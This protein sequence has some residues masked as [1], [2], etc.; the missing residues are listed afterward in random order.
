MPSFEKAKRQLRKEEEIREEKVGIRGKESQKVKELL[1]TSDDI[2]EK[3]RQTEEGKKNEE[4]IRQYAQELGI[5]KEE[6]EKNF[7][8]GLRHNIKAGYKLDLI[9]AQED[10]E[11]IIGA[12]VLNFRSTLRFFLRKK[13]KREEEETP[14]II[15]EIAKRGYLV[16]PRIL[17]ELKEEY[18][19]VEDGIIKHFAVN[20]PTNPKE[21]LKKALN[22]VKELKEEN[23]DIEDWIIKHF[24][25]RYPKNPKEALKKA[26]NTIKDLKDKYPNIE[27]WII[28]RFVVYNPTKKEEDFENILKTIDELKETYPNVDE[29]MIK[30][31][32]IAYNQPK[33]LLKE[34]QKDPE[35]MKELEE[36]TRKFKSLFI[37]KKN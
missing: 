4:K 6:L 30:I 25:V 15:I 18:S 26:L 31:V 13:E 32:A 29:E 20:N 22:T 33:E 35:K 34:A 9:N 7:K 28:K 24:A 11:D 3:L 1:E 2:L 19:D 36:F 14:G 16:P 10:I 8:D 23:P 21:A 37:L 12:Y 17:D 27:D 5:K